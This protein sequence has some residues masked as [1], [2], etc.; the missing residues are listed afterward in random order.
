MHATPPPSKTPRCNGTVG[1]DPW[2]ATGGP[3]LQ[4]S[5]PCRALFTFF[6]LPPDLKIAGNSIFILLSK[7]FFLSY[8]APLPNSRTS[9]GAP[10]PSSRAFWVAAVMGKQVTSV[11]KPDHE[12]IEW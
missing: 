8:T 12:N 5:S 1:A 9:R 7:N 3:D 2:V 10:A 11:I 4:A 6:S